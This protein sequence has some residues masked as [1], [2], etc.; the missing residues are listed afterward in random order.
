MSPQ[1]NAHKA[2]SAATRTVAKTRQI[3]MLYDG[4]L[5]FIKQA[6]VAITDKRIEDRFNLLV[7]A[8]DIIVG[9][10]NSIDFENGGAVAHTLHHFY[11]NMSVRI[12][13]VNLHPRDS[14][15]LC[16]GIIEDLKQMR[17]TWDSIDRGA[18][19]AA[20][21]ANTTAAPAVPAAITGSKGGSGDNV[22]LSA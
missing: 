13:S 21:A 12:L 4:A 10:Q 11:T 8:S 14:L 22:T 18:V 3:V 17:D 15:A 6:R 20:A 7:R 5:R 1:K 16:D 2:Y 9:L 19:A